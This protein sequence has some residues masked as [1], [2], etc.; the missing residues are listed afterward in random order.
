MRPETPYLGG[1]QEA[2]DQPQ[3]VPLM[4]RSHTQNNQAHHPISERDHQPPMEKAHFHHL[5]PGIHTRILSATTN[6]LWP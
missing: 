4:W 1:I 5:Y 6:S 2:G 3:L